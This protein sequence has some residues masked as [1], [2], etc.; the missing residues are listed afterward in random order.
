MLGSSGSGASSLIFFTDGSEPS[1]NINYK[2]KFKKKTQF[3][4]WCHFC[5]RRHFSFPF[6]FFRRH[7]WE[8]TFNYR[9]RLRKCVLCTVYCISKKTLE[10]HFFEF[11]ASVSYKY[12]KGQ[13]EKII[14]KL[15][16][17]N[18]LED[19]RFANQT[20]SSLKFCKV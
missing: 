9:H 4:I 17:T 1:V 6:L 15:L 20:S 11:L 10:K 14:K 2:P 8:S 7:F 19:R 13:Q 12:K 5:Y 3:S 18:L 16:K